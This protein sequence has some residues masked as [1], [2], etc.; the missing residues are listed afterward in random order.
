MLL[1]RTQLN[2]YRKDMQDKMYKFDWTRFNY[3]NAYTTDE[4]HIY[5]IVNNGITRI[6]VQPI[7]SYETI[8]ALAIKVTQS[9]NTTYDFYEIGKYSRTTSKQVTQIYN[10]LY[11]TYNRYYVDRV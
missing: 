1:N 9:N 10:K 2:E 11:A 7:R 8:V 3:C 6:E 4:T 5:F